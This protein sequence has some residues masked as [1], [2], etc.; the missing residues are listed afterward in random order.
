MNA[1]ASKP[2]LDS[3]SSDALASRISVLLSRERSCVVQFLW[4][5]AEVD[6]RKLHLQLGYSSLFVYCTDALHLTKA[7]AYRRT[8]AAALLNRFPAAAEL[9]ADGRLCLTTLA[10]LKD[11]L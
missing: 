6:R 3:L 10:A 8:T 11:V 5:L 2:T 7:S 9:L 1:N 4:H